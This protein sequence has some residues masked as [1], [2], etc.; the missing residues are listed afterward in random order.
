M[1][2]AMLGVRQGQ[3]QGKRTGREA[4]VR[5]PTMTDE[6]RGR[7]RLVRG[8]RRC[9]LYLTPRH[10][11]PTPPPAWQ[12]EEA[13]RGRPGKRGIKKRIW[14]QKPLWEEN[15]R[16][17][18]SWE[19]IQYCKNPRMLCKPRGGCNGCCCETVRKVLKKYI[20]VYVVANYYSSSSYCN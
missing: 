17:H 6:T 10:T 14:T 13:V 4:G 5:K 12:D 20:K 7:A 3:G 8:A 16:A 2:R 19:R 1:D 18:E 15:M 9:L 11:T